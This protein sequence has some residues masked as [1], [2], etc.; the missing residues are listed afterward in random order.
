MLEQHAGKLEV[1]LT[2]LSYAVLYGNCRICNRV[3]QQV[4]FSFQGLETILT[5]QYV[6]WMHSYKLLPCRVPFS[7][8]LLVWW[9]DATLK[10]KV[11]QYPDEYAKIVF[12]KYFDLKLSFQD[13]QG[14]CTLQVWLQAAAS[15]SLWTSGCV[16]HFMLLPGQLGRLKILRLANFERATVLSAL[17]PTVPTQQ[18]LNNRDGKNTSASG[19]NPV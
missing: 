1:S 10:H 11:H 7:L 6:M 18:L 3:R 14:N 15:I 8:P 13:S 17:F 12:E 9:N 4:H 16:S 5:C 2:Y 19:V